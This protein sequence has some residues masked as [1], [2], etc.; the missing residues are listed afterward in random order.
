MIAVHNIRI[1]QLLPLVCTVSPLVQLQ[2]EKLLSQVI[3]Y[4]LTPVDPKLHQ[5]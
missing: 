3:Y 5:S 1:L 2:L 4:K